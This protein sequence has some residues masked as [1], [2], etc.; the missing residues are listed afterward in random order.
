[1]TDVVKNKDGKIE[2]LKRRYLSP[3]FGSFCNNW[4]HPHTSMMQT[5][6]TSNVDENGQSTPNF[7]G[8]HDVGY[9]TFPDCDG[10]RI[11]ADCKER[12]VGDPAKQKKCEGTCFTK[13]CYVDPCNCDKSDVTQTAQFASVSKFGFARAKKAELL[14]HSYETCGFVGGSYMGT[15]CGGNETKDDC[16]KKVSCKWNGVDACEVKAP[17]EFAEY[18]DCPAKSIIHCQHMMIEVLYID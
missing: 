3:H 14:A 18:W 2:K 16:D 5:V 12:T 17:E 9:G 11:P 6:K 15:R 4:D 13:F 7:Y 10:I 1:M 8:T